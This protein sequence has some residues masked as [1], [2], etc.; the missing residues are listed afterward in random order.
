MHSPEASADRKGT[1]RLLGGSQLP[2]HSEGGRVLQ[3]GQIVAKTSPGRPHSAHCGS[4]FLGRPRCSTRA[5]GAAHYSRLHSA[6][7]ENPQGLAPQSASVPGTSPGPLGVFLICC[8]RSAPRKVW[9]SG[10]P[11]EPP[12]PTNVFHGS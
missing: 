2:R 10:H 4:S 11:P 1:G 7:Q 12:L 8:F 5:S 3:E 6:L 9:S